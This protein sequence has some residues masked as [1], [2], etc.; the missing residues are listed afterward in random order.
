MLPF[1]APTMLQQDLP[2]DSGS[3]LLL[4]A[5]RRLIIQGLDDSGVASQFVRS[6]GGS[7]RRPLILVRV[8][9]DEMVTSAC[10]TI[11]IAPCCCQRM[12]IAEATFLEAAVRLPTR[13]LAARLLLADLLANRHPDGALAS[14]E[15]VVGAFADA[16]HPIG[17]WA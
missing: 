16:G 12:T 17:G 11:H 2:A 3:R 1:P 6:F 15:A 14:L 10:A 4:L 7:F 13:P 5:F 8:L 9:I